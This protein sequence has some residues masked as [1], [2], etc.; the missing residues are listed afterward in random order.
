MQDSGGTDDP[1]SRVADPAL[2]FDADLRCTAATEAARE[3]FAEPLGADAER[4]LDA[5]T[6]DALA[7]TLDAGD[8]RTLTIPGPRS[9]WRARAYPDGDSVSL[10]LF[11]RLG[12]PADEPAGVE[13]PGRMLRALVDNT[14]EAVFVKDRDG[15]YL[16]MND[17]A[18]DLFDI[19]AEAAL[20]R[21]DRDLF[22]AESAA[23]IMADDREIMTTGE[24]KRFR[25]ERRI[26]GERVAFLTSKFPYRDETGEIAGVMGTSRDI[27]ERERRKRDLERSRD[28]LARTERL[29][30]TGGWEYD[31]E[32]EE[33]RWTEGAYRIHGADF[34][35]D[36]V[37]DPESVMELYHPEDRE[38][39]RE[40]I[41]ACFDGGEF[42]VEY[43]AVVDG[44]T[45]WLRALGEPVEEDG[46]VVTIR[47]AVRDVT[48]R[49]RRELELERQN[50]RLEEFATVVSHDLRNPMNV[51]RVHAEELAAE[52]GDRAREILTSLD[53][54][55]E[56]VEDTLTL[57]RQGRT[58]SDPEAVDLDR[59]VRDCWTQIGIDGGV[60][61]TLETDDLPTIRGDP[62]RLRNLFEN[63]LRNSMEHGSTSSRTE[64]DGAAES[65]TV[66]VGFDAPT[67]VYVADDG[68]G[69]P[70]DRRESVYEAGWTT[71]ADGTGFGL[72]IVNR[73][74]EAHGW[75]P[76]VTESDL[77][78]A[79]FEFGGVDVVAE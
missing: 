76:S 54:M 63:L 32:S 78:G 2:T 5:A 73:I 15:E 6:A 21:D 51:A 28:M 50:E 35:A 77:G 12:D 75:S 23:D 42:D 1:R 62:A 55:E 67:T 45:R 37:E 10:V 17:A 34:E 18:A 65:V 4:L 27:T 9:R 7:A 30:D 64:S 79:R 52:G 48:D 44:E 43:R 25:S 33:I 60:E 19:D 58:V 36:T 26:D 46:E 31:L 3:R 61:T 8:P 66:R 14:D 13:D 56:I 22:D 41:R 38:R 59:L 24:P 71:D 53:R 20:G 69:I 11:D 16:L 49:K 39:I 29:G 70:P 74:A 68:P 47:G 40:G 57:A 72:S